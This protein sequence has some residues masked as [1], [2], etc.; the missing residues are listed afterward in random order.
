M[1]RRAQ[2]ALLA[3][4]IM[5][6]VAWAGTYYWTFQEIQGSFRSDSPVGMGMRTGS[7]WP[8]VF[9]ADNNSVVEAHSLTPVGWM[10]APVG[11]GGSFEGRGLKTAASADGQIGATWF[12]GG[13]VEFAQSSSGGWLRKSIEAPNYSSSSTPGVA[14]FGD[15][16]P[17]LAYGLNT[18]IGMHAYNG[19]QWDGFTLLSVTNPVTMQQQAIPAINRLS[20]AVD[21]Q[22]AMSLA[23]TDSS[24]SGLKYAFRDAY[25]GTWYGS[26]LA[27][28]PPGQIE[29]ISLAFG[30]N[31]MPA[32]ASLDGGDLRYSS[33][34]AVSGT[35]SSEIVATG[36]S[37]QHINLVFDQLGN[38]AVSYVANNTV[39]F[40]TKNGPGWGQYALPTQGQQSL[41]PRSDSDAALAFDADNLPV[42][43]YAA[44][45]GHL[46]L[47]Y[48]PVLVPEPVTCVLLLV[49]L[50]AWPRRRGG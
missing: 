9:A 16:S 42:I 26:T 37:S 31:D 44:A 49:G 43:G 47:A 33:F 11:Y 4:V 38:P 34:S 5:S 48:D 23:Y 18:G 27:V 36:I 21:G 40:A 39:Y 14:F 29:D 10:G 32:I 50:M 35:W 19:S 1:L 6:S 28:G 25:S 22:D 7:T 45:D 12:Q 8:V 15:S 46:V 2:H 13:R 20:V 24:G 3:S 41:V 30:L 17:L